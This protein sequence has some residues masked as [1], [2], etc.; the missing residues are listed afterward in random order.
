M[1]RTRTYIDTKR[2]ESQDP[3]RLD[4]ATMKF[5]EEKYLGDHRK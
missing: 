4:E 3:G 5:S 1:Y 2:N